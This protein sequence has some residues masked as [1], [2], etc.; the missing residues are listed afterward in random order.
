MKN[1]KE[2]TISSEQIK[3]LETI[4]DYAF[5]SKHFDKL[6]GKSAIFCIAMYAQELG[7][8]PMT[9]LFG[10]M[11]AVQGNIEVSPRMMNTMIRKAGHK[12]EIIQS[13]DT[14][15]KIKGTRHDTKEDYVAIFSFDDAK[16]AGLVKSNGGWEKYA[17]D[18][19]FARCIS[20]LARRLF[21]DVISTA[22]VEGEMD[23]VE[24]S[25]TAQISN[26]VGEVVESH[27]EPQKVEE[28]AEEMSL[29][30]FCALLRGK[31]FFE[32]QG[33]GLD[34]YLYELSV[35]K[36]GK[37]IPIQKVMEQALKMP[38]RFVKSYN[39]WYAAQA[40][41]EEALAKS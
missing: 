37:P 19:L 28:K 23:R 27:P 24:Q 10:G 6:G 33:L 5:N 1:D 16:R 21:A 22:Y 3:A 31:G 25:E 18:M 4:A 40:E 34:A 26:V 41:A 32:F 17:S 14:I 20:R 35:K 30:D 2:I 8:N 36:G 15:C 29:V 7:L 39:E 9:C 38:D 13:D 12:L 11:R